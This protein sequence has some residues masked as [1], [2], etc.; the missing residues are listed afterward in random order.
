MK[1]PRDLIFEKHREIVPHLDEAR[2]A[3][4]AELNSEKT[5]A[6]EVAAE[7]GVSSP[8]RIVA[9]LWRELFL[10]CRNVWAGL[11][12]TWVCI[13]IVSATTQPEA[14]P[15]S[16]EKPV[17]R[18]SPEVQN[19]LHLQRQLRADLLDLTEPLPARKDAP[20]ANRRSEIGRKFEYC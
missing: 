11:A 15:T 5:A 12:V 20:P 19:Q 2:A 9:T 8:R 3:A 18:L 14:P 6:D 7:A 13:L 17:A 10:P 4:L 16:S 1:S